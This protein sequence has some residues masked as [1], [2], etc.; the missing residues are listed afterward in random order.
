VRRYLIERDIPG[1]GEYTAEQLRQTAQASC[2]T[3][4][5]M[6]TDL[7]WEHSYITGDRM[8]CVY[9]AK[10]EELVR[11]HAKRGGFPATRVVEVSAIIDRLTASGNA[12]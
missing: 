7:Q 12:C 10:N 1:L 4:Q 3:L 9:L 6:G 8:Y 5:A 11:E 2:H